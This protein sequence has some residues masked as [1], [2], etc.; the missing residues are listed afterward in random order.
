M[1]VVV[2]RMKVVH[3]ANSEAMAQGARRADVEFI[4]DVDDFG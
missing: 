4:G 1:G 3:R 2:M